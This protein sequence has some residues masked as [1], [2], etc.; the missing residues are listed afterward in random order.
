[1]STTTWPTD[2]IATTGNRIVCLAVWASQIG[3][4]AVYLVLAVQPD[5]WRPLFAKDP[6]YAVLSGFTL[7][8]FVILW[9]VSLFGEQRRFYDRSQR[10]LY[11]QLGL[12]SHAAVLLFAVTGAWS[13]PNRIALLI[14]L[15]MLPLFT[16]AVWEAWMSVRRLPDEDQAVVDTILNGE[17]QQRGALHQARQ[18]IQHRERL[19]QVVNGLGYDLVKPKSETA[20]PAPTAVEQPEW[21][22]PDR[23]HKPLVYFLRNG[24]RIKIGTTTQLKQRIRRLSLRPENVVL[25]LDG[26]QRLERELHDK[27]ASQRVG[28]TEWFTY[29]DAVLAYVDA[30]N[31]R[32]LR[33]AEVK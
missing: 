15:G 2:R 12:L 16:A 32:A 22:I 7:A 10:R 25:L 31:A 26:G 1:M 13:L 23:Q 19:I 4:A 27:F 24:N 11:R 30:E 20:Q 3:T 17:A 6:V 18:K 29:Q 33:E 14:V 5:V 21:K 8:S 9:P 28:N